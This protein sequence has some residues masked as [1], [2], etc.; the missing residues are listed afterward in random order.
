MN[1][2]AT[3]RRAGLVAA[4]AVIGATGCDKYLEPST[5]KLAIVRAI[6]V[7]QMQT[8]APAASAENP[9]TTVT[10]NQVPLYDSVFRVYF[11]RPLKGSDVEVNPNPDK[12]FCT[13][14]DKV[15][16]QAIKSD[17]SQDAS[18]KAEICYDP[19]GPAVVVRPAVQTCL[20]FETPSS[21]YAVRF[22]DDPQWY[23]NN[24]NGYSYVVKGTGLRDSDGNALDFT[25]TYKIADFNVTKTKYIAINPEDKSE[26]DYDLAANQ[27]G[28]PPG[29]YQDATSKLYVRGNPETFSYGRSMGTFAAFGTPIS[30]F[31]NHNVAVGTGIFGN[32]SASRANDPNFALTISGSTDPNDKAD[33]TPA[34]DEL[35]NGN[36]GRVNIVPRLPLEEATKYDIIVKTTLQ[37]SPALGPVFDYCAGDSSC[38]AYNLTPSLAPSVNL[39]NQFTQSFTTAGDANTTHAQYINPR[40]NST[41]NY[42]TTD[43]VH[44]WRAA[45]ELGVG[46]VFSHP[47][48]LSGVVP[49]G[50]YQ[51]LDMSL[52][53]GA[54]GP[55][56]S[57]S[58]D[59]N[60]GANLSTDVSFDKR[61]RSIFF[62]ATKGALGLALKTDTAYRMHF[63]GLV[64][65]NDHPIADFDVDFRT[66]PFAMD[67]NR[68]GHIDFVDTNVL[69]PSKGGVDVY[70]RQVRVDTLTT[71]SNVASYFVD[72]SG[73]ADHNTAGAQTGAIPIN[74][75]T[76]VY[77]PMNAGASVQLFKGNEGTTAVAGHGG[78]A[79]LLGLGGGT[80]NNPAKIADPWS[81]KTS[82]ATVVLGED[83]W[84]YPASS[85][86]FTPDQPLEFNTTYTLVVNGV[87]TT[88]PGG[89]AIT[90]PKAV[91]PFT[92]RTFSVRGILTQFGIEN[93]SLAP[94]AQNQT[95]VRFGDVFGSLGQAGLLSGEPDDPG[96]PLYVW[97]SGAVDPTILPADAVLLY[98]S[99]GTGVKK[100]NVRY[101]F[102]FPTATNANTNGASPGM[103][104]KVYAT[105]PIK[106]ATVYTIQVTNKLVDAVYHTPIAPFSIS[107]T[108]EDPVI[109][110]A[111]PLTD[112]RT[113]AFNAAQCPA[114]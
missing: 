69:K 113:Q 5:A 82:D 97:T 30:V 51:L 103:A 33:F 21:L 17:G 28:V 37:D 75:F 2:I 48:K 7:D 56:L 12:A 38:D 54:G 73:I 35:I 71:Q 10:L 84:G 95:H 59:A 74:R 104:L 93:L 31:M 25:V 100:V 68:P 79:M 20:G 24:L 47:L 87:T 62:G 83:R 6:A 46:V 106:P 89:T 53:G 66:A 92:T 88:P 13:P 27:T 34:N 39:Q 14:S 96:N 112:P 16:F 1:T 72:F 49:V 65:V 43:Q 85:I 8:N 76:G 58:N 109:D 91:V 108:T 102:G 15:T 4:L 80:P 11:N 86:G 107:F 64:D 23:Q 111:H 78:Y 60:Q 57:V 110:P 52:N 3:T 77:V 26:K 70:T 29:L 63:S 45:N 99:T 67:V 90:A 81:G 18:V 55:A 40:P 98:E 50:T 94:V 101:D 42:P 19:A 105:D 32:T 61:H 41:G 44:W 22:E 114:Q 9:G 36:M